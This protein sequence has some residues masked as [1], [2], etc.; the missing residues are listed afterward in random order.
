MGPRASASP[1]SLLTS[2]STS[3]TGH[4]S[5]DLPGDLDSEEELRPAEML[6]LRLEVQALKHRAQLGMDPLSLARLK[7]DAGSALVSFDP[8]KLLAELGSEGKPHAE[9]GQSQADNADS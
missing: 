3:P 8:A 1:S 9:G 2:A 7:R 4:R 5:G 6:L